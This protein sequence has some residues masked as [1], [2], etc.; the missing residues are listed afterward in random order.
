MPKSEQVP[1]SAIT[2]AS[3]VVWMRAL[4]LVLPVLALF[5]LGLILITAQDRAR[6]EE[7]VLQSSRD[8]TRLQAEFFE[9]QLEMLTATLLHESRRS[10]LASFLDR[11]DLRAQ[12]EAECIDSCHTRGDLDQIRLIDLE[13]QE[14]LRINHN[15][16]TPTAVPLADLQSKAERYYFQRAIA[17]PAGAVY[18]SPFDLNQEH[19]RIEEPWKP[20]VRVATPVF[21]SNGERRGLLVFNYLGKR[22]LDRLGRG[23]RE[24]AWT[25]V[26]DSNGY[27]LQGPARESSWGFMFDRN[28]T[29]AADHPEAWS[30]MSSV[31]EGSLNAETGIYGFR[32]A[33]LGERG[34]SAPVLRIVTFVP[35]ALV[36]R[37]SRQALQRFAIGGSLMALVLL[38]IALRLAYEGALRES[39][40]QRLQVLSLRLID[41][42]ESE[43]KHLS[44]DLHDELGQIATVLNI[45]LERAR[46]S[47]DPQQKNDLI[48]QS[49]DHTSRL[50]EELHRISASLRSSLLDDLGLE[51]ALRASAEEHAR[52]CGSP[53]EVELELD[54]EDSLDGR[55]S[56]NLYRVVQEALTNISRHAQATRVSI[57]VRQLDGGLELE[58]SDDGVGFEILRDNG[59]R[60]GL[61]SMRER[62]ELLGGRFSIRSAPDRGTV[63]EA[64]IP[65][66]DP[67]EESA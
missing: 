24:G 25:G 6:D 49:R 11:E 65:A 45:D 66:R 1:K 41:A 23:T 67:E 51:A 46:R 58:V 17:L 64:S 21:D 20:V 61:I 4:P 32:T 31:A 13:G 42:Q 22:L 29:F 9:R 33:A 8:A 30:T 60:L 16:G 52:A 50:L 5:S 2:Y 10:L 54:D 26:V 57:R 55:V 38:I 35:A 63:V 14:V 7:L 3:R 47:D 19:G 12:L 56:E 36:H 62:V 40:E 27:Y 59:D 28:P 53:V 43:R 48:A 18:V 44:R 37:T 39:H 34:G 15:D